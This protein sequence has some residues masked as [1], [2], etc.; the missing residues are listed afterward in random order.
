MFM[1]KTCL[2]S[3]FIF[4]LNYAHAQTKG[5]VVDIETRLP[6]RNVIISMN[7]NKGVTTKWDGSFSI[8][9]DFGSATFTRS[10][11][12]SRNMKREEIKD[13]VFLLPNGRSLA[14]VVVYAKKPGKKFNYNG[15]TSTDMKLINN[16]DM[17]KGF[18]ILGFIPLAISALKDKH[19][20]SKNEKLKQQLDNY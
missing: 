7:T 18:N 14:E 12:L 9:D 4:L 10:G 13:T 15:M 20:M 8:G 2:V 17:A 1:R 11:Y 3:Y 19:K 5:V 16:Q 6:I